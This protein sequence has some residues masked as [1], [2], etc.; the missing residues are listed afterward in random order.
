MT[1]QRQP[2]RPAIWTAALLAL[3]LAADA[4]AQTATVELDA[5]EAPR[6]VLHVHL[7]LPAQPD[8]LTLLYPKWIPGEHGPTGSLNGVVGLRF[9]SQGRELEWRRDPLDMFT[10]HLEVPG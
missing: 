8:P 10:F 2:I 5:R 1:S 7:V 6:H 9:R 3:N 4:A